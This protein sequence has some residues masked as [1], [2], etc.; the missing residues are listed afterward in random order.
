MPTPFWNCQTFYIN[1]CWV[2]RNS[3]A[4]S[5]NLSLFALHQSGFW[6][7]LWT[8]CKLKMLM[9][10][11]FYKYFTNDFNSK[12][13]LVNNL[14]LSDILV[15][16]VVLIY[17]ME[18]LKPNKLVKFSD[19]QKKSTCFSKSYLGYPWSKNNSH[20]FFKL[21]NHVKCASKVSTPC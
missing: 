14:H 7:A 9:L 19:F 10:F 15:K 2:F 11:R 12:Y 1:V 18:P 20:V 8:Y 3:R 16:S 21:F 13:L 6:V 4:V 5:W 17:P